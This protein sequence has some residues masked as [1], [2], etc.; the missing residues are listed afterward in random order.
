MTSTRSHAPIR[1]VLRAAG[2]HRE[3]SSA[4]AGPG[5]ESRHLS[6]DDEDQWMEAR[7]QSLARMRAKREKRREMGTLG[8]PPAPLGLEMYEPELGYRYESDT[9]SG[10]ASGGGSW[11]SSVEKEIGLVQARDRNRAHQA[12]GEAT[13]NASATRTGTRPKSKAV[14]V[15]ASQSQAQVRKARRPS[16]GLVV[17]N[18]DEYEHDQPERPDYR[19]HHSSGRVHVARQEVET[20]EWTGGTPAHTYI[21]QYGRRGDGYE[22]E[23]GTVSYTYGQG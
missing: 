4:G 12:R 19:K 20:N 1:E 17:S 21:D 23:D 14:P 9:G 18:P 6:V 15:P 13:V 10:S 2:Y 7:R 22:T 11:T 5:P 3:M 16:K 8:T